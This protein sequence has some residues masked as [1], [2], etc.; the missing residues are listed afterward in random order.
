MSHVE[1][2]FEVTDRMLRSGLEATSESEIKEQLTTRFA[3][4]LSPRRVTKGTTTGEGD[5][6]TV[7]Y[8]EG[9]P[10]VEQLQRAANRMGRLFA[11]EEVRVVD[12]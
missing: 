12:V 3:D 2:V 1:M 6:V 10:T 7:V 9:N 8:R 11:V 4:D 5:T